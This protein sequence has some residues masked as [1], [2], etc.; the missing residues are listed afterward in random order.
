[1]PG[2]ANR[3]GMLRTPPGPREWGRLRQRRPD[4]LDA[5][6]RDPDP[7][8]FEDVLRVYF[9]ALNRAPRRPN[10]PGDAKEAP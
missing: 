1:M 2:G 8:G 6:A 5:A 9:R 4:E 3:P 7:P 10:D